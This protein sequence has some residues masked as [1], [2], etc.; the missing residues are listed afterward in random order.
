MKGLSLEVR[1]GLLILVALVIMGGFV[2]LLGGVH[3]EDG[4]AVYVDFNNPGGIKPGA[5]V[6][7]AGVRIGTV[8]NSEY[9]GGRLD[10]KTGKHPLVRIELKIDDKVKDTIHEDA[11]FYVTSQ[12][13]LGEPFVAIDPGSPEKKI[14][15]EGSI[16]HG[17][18][19]PRLDLA[20]A[21]G[22]ELLETMVSALR[23]NREE[24]EGLLSNASG[25][26]KGMNELLNEN[27]DRINR[28]MANVET[29]TSEGTLMIQ[30]V[31]QNYV[32]GP[33]PKRIMQ[34]LDKTLA[35]TSDQAGPLMQDVRGAVADARDMLGPEQRDKIKSTINDA[36]ALADKAK[37]TLADTQQIVTHMKRGQGTVGALLMDEAIYDDVQEMLRDIKHNPWKLFWRE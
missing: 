9:L 37:V 5:P 16:V 19:P 29:A 15:P 17:I 2:F 12:G 8:K 14:L 32:E 18:D 36:A 28:I 30:A 6:R 35:A 4:Y 21:M 10:P 23:N 20:L 25:T 26:L 33:Q 31:R 34:N 27:H 11:L 1:V 22:Y 13:V 7:V 3:L 24:L